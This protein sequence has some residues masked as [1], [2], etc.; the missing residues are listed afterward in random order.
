MNRKKWLCATKMTGR[1]IK[2]ILT[3]LL[4]SNSYQKRRK[5]VCSKKLFLYIRL[6]LGGRKTQV[7]EKLWWRYLC[8]FP[9]ISR[10]QSGK[11]KKYKL[12]LITSVRNINRDRYWHHFSE[13]QCSFRS[14]F[15][16][17]YL[18]NTSKNFCKTYRKKSVP[19]SL[20]I[21]SCPE[22]FLVTAA[23]MCS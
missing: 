16:E 7:P 14:S 4:A 17:V 9:L 5:K 21:S 15:P 18:K 12:R 20:F 1:R 6:S 22:V 11:R 3:F 13:I 8:K 19:E 23:Q 10:K 2:M